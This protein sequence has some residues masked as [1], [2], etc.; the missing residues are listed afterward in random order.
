[1][2]SPARSRRRRYGYARP[3]GEIKAGEVFGARDVVGG[4]AGS[5]ESKL[6]EARTIAMREMQEEAAR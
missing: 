3:A 6:A 5:Y 1:L 2:I 4:R